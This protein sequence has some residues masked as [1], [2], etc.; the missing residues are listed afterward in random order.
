MTQ[1]AMP[2]SF[3]LSAA[4]A[5]IVPTTLQAQLTQPP[6]EELKRLVAQREQE[7]RAAQFEL[8]HARA[9][10]ARAEGKSALAAAEWRKALSLFE[11]HLNSVQDL[12]T[13]G[14]ICSAEPFE[15]AQGAVTVA[16]VRLA[17]VENRRDDLRAELPKL[18]K[19]YEL[20]VRRYKYLSEHGVI[21]DKDAQEALKEFEAELRWARE[22]LAALTGD[23][24][25]QDKTDKN[26]N[27]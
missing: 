18:I 26:G 19:Y 20:Q 2:A 3:A 17:D 16:R 24:A 13:Q 15:E 5:L 11:S 1:T 9:R 10:L 6:V 25:S 8:G 21:L 27:P 22:R 23:P 4:L 14:R 12:Y 7:F